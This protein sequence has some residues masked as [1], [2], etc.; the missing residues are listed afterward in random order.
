MR[1]PAPAFATAQTV[2]AARH[3]GRLVREARLARRMPQSEL[4]ARAKTSKPTVIRIEKGAVETALGTWLA[5]MEQVGLLGK[6][7]EMEDKVSSE[8]AAQQRA[9]RAR[10]KATP[11]LDF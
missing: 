8:L 11:D 9:R 10:P 7:L 4:A 3:L 2:R 1:T 5:V 6:I